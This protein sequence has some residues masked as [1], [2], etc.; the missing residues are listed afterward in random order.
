[1][2]PT[3]RSKTSAKATPS[4]SVATT[5]SSSTSSKTTP[6][7]PQTPTE[8][9]RATLW[10]TALRYVAITFPIFLLAYG[11]LLYLQY[12]QIPPNSDPYFDHRVRAAR[13]LNLTQPLDKHL[14]NS[15]LI[16]VYDDENVS[17]DKIVEK[18]ERFETRDASSLIFERIKFSQKGA[19]VD[20][21]VKG[22]LVLVHNI[23]SHQGAMVDDADETLWIEKTLI[24]QHGFA[25]YRFD[26]R[27]HGKSS[28]PRCFISNLLPSK[29]KVDLFDDLDQVLTERM[30]LLKAQFNST[31]GNIP[32]FVVGQSL[33]AL[34]TIGYETLYRKDHRTIDGAILLSIPLISGSKPSETDPEKNP[35]KLLTPWKDLFMRILAYR[36]PSY[37]VR[38][39]LPPT[40][41]TTRIGKRINKLASDKYNYRGAAVFAEEQLYDLINNVIHFSTP[42]EIDSKQ[43][44]NPRYSIQGVGG[45]TLSHR[46]DMWTM[47]TARAVLELL[48]ELNKSEVLKNLKTPRIMIGHG[49]RDVVVSENSIHR[50]VKLSSCE[51][52]VRKFT[53]YDGLL[54]DLLNDVG[55][56]KVRNDI[57]TWLSE[58]E[59][60]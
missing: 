25:V 16:E 28:G 5:P 21:G 32:V 23:G 14:T 53:K 8:S 47:T 7:T 10:F 49:T 57:V 20:G 39:L 6:I 48:E 42:A 40:E 19:S 27:G 31:R 1:M 43:R 3:K 52:C 35:E 13:K 60:K 56:D 26:M 24:S 2:A 50:L 12:S 4:S 58:L 36:M 33:G 30:D 37:P 41:L 44:A 18:S 51:T 29:G 15:K 54:H 17:I 38:S 22:I 9:K 46:S 55:S 11:T 45:V 34:L 59:G